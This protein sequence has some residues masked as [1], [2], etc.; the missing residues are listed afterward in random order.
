MSPVSRYRKSL[1]SRILRARPRLGLALLFGLASP[2]CNIVQGFQDAGDTLFPQQ[3]S[4]LAAPGLQL[5]AGGYSSLDVALGTDI[6]LLARATDDDSGKLYAMRYTDREPCLIPSVTNYRATRGATRTRPIL[7]YFQESVSQGTLHFA[8]TSCTLYDL[9][10]EN[11]RL[12]IAETETSEVVWAGTDLWL[13]TPETGSQEQVAENVSDVLGDVFSGRHA[14]RS[15]G[16]IAILSSDWKT[17]QFFGDAVG[18]VLSAGKSLFFSDNTGIHRI[19]AKAAGQPLE[20]ESVATDACA[21][22]IQDAPWVLFRSP[23]TGGPVIAFHEPSGKQYPL[24]FDADPRNL[25]LVAARQSRGLDPTQDPFWFFGLRSGDSADSANTLVVRTPTG[26][27][28]ALGAHSTLKQLRLLET[29]TE[30]HGYAMVDIAGEVG[31]YLW[32]DPQGNTQVLA[33]QALWR[34]SRL[35]V[36][37]D[38]TFLGKLAVTS[39]NRLLVLE[40]DVPAPSFE[41]KDSNGQWTALFHDVKMPQEQGQISVFS[42]T[43]DA[44]NATPIDQPFV[45][46]ELLPVTGNA[47]LFRSFPL[48]SVLSGVIYLA[49]YDVAAGTG[50][51]EYRNLDLRFTGQVAEG[52]SAYIVAQNQVLYAIPHGEHAGI[53]LVS[54]K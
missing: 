49:D 11:A 6:H 31:R 27:E 32:W 41:Y 15:A 45:L 19:V 33:E 37:F 46:P 13:A 53:W 21:L 39:G 10:F 35:I 25:K 36:D 44:L 29:E 28:F 47:G 34:P 18:T 9:T 3:T 30:T 7:S 12:P 42:G 24:D 20:A 22:G 26:N 4:Y 14:L 40:K 1:T 54:G 38:G 51:L 8:D 48:N 50:R 16:R 5:A 17:P 2:S 23:C 52:V 43:L